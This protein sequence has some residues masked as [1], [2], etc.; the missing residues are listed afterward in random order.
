MTTSSGGSAMIGVS[1]LTAPKM[2]ISEPS[3]FAVIE[4]FFLLRP[5]TTSSAR[6]GSVVVWEARSVP[7]PEDTAARVRPA[8]L[9]Y[10]AVGGLI[11]LLVAH[12]V[13]AGQVHGY[14]RA[15]SAQLFAPEPYKAMV[16]ETPGKLGRPEDK[17]KGGY[18]DGHGDGHGDGTK[19][20]HGAESK[21]A[22]GAEAKDGAEAQDA[23]KDEGH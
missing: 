14:T 16:L 7:A 12:T 17:A 11:A 4:T 8:P 3:K 20:A 13:L 15:I 22:H 10:V 2:R 18:G 23:P 21:D 1:R 6:A 5:S 9:A 19:D